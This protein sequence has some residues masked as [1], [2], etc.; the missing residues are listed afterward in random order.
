[1]I[2]GLDQQITIFIY[3]SADAYYDFLR[4]GDLDPERSVNTVVPPIFHDFR[5]MVQVIVHRP[6]LIENG[7]Q[8][9]TE[10]ISLSRSE[11]QRRRSKRNLGSALVDVQ[12]DS[13]NRER[14]PVA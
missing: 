5:R 10:I 8:K 2:V 6:Q 14:N 1:M 12:T 13:E 7:S 9:E 3:S 4:E 11:M